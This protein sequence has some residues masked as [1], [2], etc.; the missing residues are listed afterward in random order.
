MLTAGIDIGSLTAKA[1]IM[2]EKR[3]I[4]SSIIKAGPNPSKSAE[5][6]MTECLVQKNISPSSIEKCCST[7]YGRFNTPFSDFNMSEISCHGMGAFWGNSNIRT[8][9]DIGGQDCKIISI[10]EN[11][12]VKDFV[13]NDKCAAGTGRSLEILSRTIGITYEELGDLAAKSRK[14]LLLTNK[15]SIFM[16]LEV[17]ELMQRGKKPS[18]IANALAKAVA[19]RIVALTGSVEISEGVCITGGVSK[20]RAVVRH[21]E[22]QLKTEFQLP[23]IDPQLAGATGA[24]V[25]ASQSMNA[26]YERR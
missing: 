21:L 23:G 17:M 14:S 16:E 22:N 10:D 5:E 3:I 8:I 2:E 18:D 9:I 12:M 7:G 4:S 15:C 25:F 26:N 19:G 13:M 11:G 20:N 1:V 24:A 6:V